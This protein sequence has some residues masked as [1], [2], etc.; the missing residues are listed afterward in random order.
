MKLTFKLAV[1]LCLFLGYSSNALAEENVKHFPHPDRIRYDGS[2]MTIEGKDL[3]IYSAAFHY[4]RCPEPLWRDRFKKIK[5]AGFNTVET[6]IPWNWH[7]RKMP[8]SPD[9]PGEFDF[10]DLRRWLKMAQDEFGFYTIVRP[11]PFICAEYSGGGYPRWLAK[12]RPE[13]FN[14][15]WLRS[16]DYQHIRWCQHWYDAVCKEL[17][18]EQITHKPKGEKG[19]ILIQIENEYNHHDCENKEELLKALYRSVRKNNI[20]IPVFTCLTKECRNSENPELSQVFD[21][22]NYYVGLSSAPDCAYRM[23]NLKQSQPDAPGFVTELQGGWFSLVTG[24]LSEDHYSDAR[25][26]RALGLMSMLG[27]A[28]GLN[29]YMF[30]GGTHFDGWGARGMTTSYDYNAAIRENGATGEKYVESKAIGEF[31]HTYNDQLAR[32]KGGPCLLE[33]APQSL[34]GGIRVAEDGTRFI[35]LHNTDPQQAIKGKVRIIPGKSPKHSDPMYNI[36][37]HGEKVLIDAEAEENH[38]LQN[39]SPIEVE[40]ELPALGAKVLVLPANSSVKKGTWWPKAQMQT[41][42]PSRLPDPVRVTS[43]WKKEDP[44]AEAQW[45]STPRL[46]SLSDLGVNDFRYSL[47]RTHVNL[48]A[49]QVKDECFLLFNMFTR[50]I[51]SVQVNNKQARRLFPD[52]AD[53]QSWTTRDCFERIRPDEYDNRFDVTGLLHEGNNEI[54]VVYENLGHAHGYYPME[55]LAGIRQAGLSITES[56]LTHPLEWECAT[57]M[58]GITAGWQLPEYSPANWEKV[59]LDSN[60]NIPEKGNDIQPKG[61]PDGLFT[62]YRIEFELPEQQSGVWIPWLARINASGNGY[63]WL[64]GHNI[65]RHW[66]AGPQR[67][68]Y[69]PECWLNFGSQKN[70][71]VMGLRQTAN[72]AVLKALEI[73]PYPNAAEIRK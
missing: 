73:A 53:A 33:N 59:A 21:S 18:D 34:F 25:H 58:A 47:Y 11:G 44:F 38:N 15:F 14:G 54:L 2:C 6:Y 48:N 55:E 9:A 36:N 22:D 72:G 1:L 24:R 3:F 37:Q 65:G 57:D 52:K 42:R 68:Y 7:E 45:K 56:A 67:E 39:V 5:E 35:F 64:N 70:V 26:F 32:S 50:D 69:L 27:G 60:C 63:M 62:W 23:E 17:V 30:F 10:A 29:Y 8:A 20:D 12:F 43:A 66:E 61:S 41:L 46:V 49:Q 31:I 13:G 40:Y 51:V 28:T 71:L 16:A 4:F 19:I